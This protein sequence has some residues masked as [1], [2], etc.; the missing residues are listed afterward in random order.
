[1]LARCYPWSKERLNA[2]LI[3]MITHKF[4]FISVMDS[5]HEMP[6]GWLAITLQVPPVDLII[7]PWGVN[8]LVH[9]N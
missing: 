4:V 1:M 2:A 5:S 6:L 3:V 8:H 7:R 9:I